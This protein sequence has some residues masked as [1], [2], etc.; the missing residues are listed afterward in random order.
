MGSDDLW[1]AF[2]LVREKNQG[3]CELVPTLEIRVDGGPRRCR[4]AAR[5]ALAAMLFTGGPAVA[6]VAQGADR[7][8][9]ISL[10]G[11]PQRSPDL[12]RKLAAALAGRGP[13]YKPHTRH[14]NPD[15]SPKY[16][17]RLILED[18]PYL[19]QHAHNPVDW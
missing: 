18:S 2:G 4:L 13:S 10:P 14:L 12:A 1:S 19:L 5:I 17:N 15:G 6:T 3:A 11:A 7:Q 9:A 16:T 8:P